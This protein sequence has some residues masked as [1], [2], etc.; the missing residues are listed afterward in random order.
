MMNIISR[1]LTINLI[2]WSF[3][4]LPFGYLLVAAGKVLAPSGKYAHSMAR[5][6][7][8][9]ISI[10]AGTRIHVEGR[11]NLD[12]RQRYLIITNHKSAMDIPVL[13][14]IL[15]IHYK[16]FAA[17]FLFRYPFFGWSMSKAGYLPIDRTNRD[18]AYASIHKGSRLLENDVAS[19]LIF[20]EGTRSARIEVQ[21]FKKG[22]LHIA[23]ATHRP[24]LPVVLYGT[25]NLKYKNS[26]WYHP[27]RV[28]VRI[29]PP[30]STTHLKESGWDE[31]RSRAENAVRSAYLDIHREQTSAVREQ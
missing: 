16:F 3:L 9:M 10:L 7:L 31:L 18:A 30:I 13:A 20:P 17:H 4:V 5:W 24:I 1:V 15:H 29:L 21:P 28:H 27:G 2:F 26:F 8:A 12:R 14:R 22:F 19:L 11:E 6:Y 23:Q 25:E